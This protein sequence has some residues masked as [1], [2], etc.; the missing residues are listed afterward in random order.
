MRFLSNC[1]RIYNIEG[2]HIMK[3]TIL[4]LIESNPRG[5]VNRIKA[6]QKLLDW[7]DSNTLSDSEHLPTKIRSAVYSETDTCPH[8]NKLKFTRIST[9]FSNCGPASR[10]ACTREK[11]AQSVKQT[12]NT[13]TDEQ[14]AAA[15][16]KRQQTMIKKYGTAYNS[17]RQEIKHLWRK[18]KISQFAHTRLTDAL[19]L[20][21]EYIEKDRTSVDIADELGVYYSTVID[22]C[23]SHGFKIKQ[24]SNYSLIEREILDWIQSQNFVC[25]NNTKSYLNGKEI[26]I[27]V[28]A[29]KLA[30]EVNGL[31]WHSFDFKK[32][33]NENRYRHLEKTLRAEEKGI[34]LIHVTDWE[35]QHKQAIVKSLIQSKLGISKK[36]HARK[37]VARPVPSCDARQFFKHNHIQGSCNSSVYFGL[38]HQDQLVMAVSAGRSRFNQDSVELHRLA[39]LNSVTVVGGAGKLIKQLKQYYNNG[40]IKTYCDRD[41]SNGAVY[42]ALGFELIG[43]TGPGYFWTDGNNIISR[44]KAQKKNLSKWLPNFDPNLSESQNMFANSY[45]RYWNCGN[46]IFEV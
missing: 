3:N 17:Q 11:I 8:G 14:Q 45:R 15:N 24:F 36:I 35:W 26:D 43:E 6:D 9:P 25:E 29:K 40:K 44:Y 31:Y 41:K 38:Y 37:T 20:R 22:Y 12:K 1:V 33:D 18:P 30:I 19:W 23:K 28:P 46:L 13:V 42:K 39:S 34:N 5:Y 10:C 7:V 21:T 2:K 27:Y 16:S 32:Q 4:K